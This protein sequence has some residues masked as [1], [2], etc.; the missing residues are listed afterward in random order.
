MGNLNSNK[1]FAWTPDDHKVSKIMQAYF[2]NFIRTGS[3]NGPGLPE[4]PAITKDNVTFMNINV[5]TKPEKETNRGR[6]LFLDKQ[7]TAQ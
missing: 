6:Y 3:P 4:W 5:N 7:M 2:I 1:V